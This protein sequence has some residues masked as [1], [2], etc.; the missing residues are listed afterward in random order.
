MTINVP[1]SVQFDGHIIRTCQLFKKFKFR[2]Y[3]NPSQK[4]I[5]TAQLRSFDA[6]MTVF[7]LMQFNKDNLIG[8]NP[9]KMLNC[10]HY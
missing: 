5:S 7:L 10:L 1:K 4:I 8:G 2:K 9:F 3:G 6:H